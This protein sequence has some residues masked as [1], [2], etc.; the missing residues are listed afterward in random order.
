[1]S[2]YTLLNA[3]LGYRFFGNQAKLSLNAFNLFDGQHRQ[4]PFGQLIGRRVMA[5]ATYRS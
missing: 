5:T 1:M 4:H 2:D 3:R